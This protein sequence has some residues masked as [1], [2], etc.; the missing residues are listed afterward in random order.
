ML[1][2]CELYQDYTDVV[3]YS[4]VVTL[5]DLEKNDYTLAVNSYIEKPKAPPI[6]PA[7]VKQEYFAALENVKE[8]ED[9][10]YNLLK[11]GGYLE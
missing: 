7:K 10:L 1:T 6:D 5:E 8:C 4:K 11:E 9:K 3:G 2:F